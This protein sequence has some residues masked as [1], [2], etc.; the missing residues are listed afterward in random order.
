M[1]EYKVYKVIH[2]VG[3]LLCASRNKTESSTIFGLRVHIY[4]C[5]YTEKDLEWQTPDNRKD[6][7]IGRGG[8]KWDFSTLF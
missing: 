1:I 6:K 2:M 7:D 3:S 4:A 8:V 5:N